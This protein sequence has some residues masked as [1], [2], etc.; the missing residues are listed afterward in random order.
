MGIAATRSNGFIKE[1]TEC[2]LKMRDILIFNVVVDSVNDIVDCFVIKTDQTL[3][4][5][6]SIPFDILSVNT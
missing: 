1:R 4:V 5:V 6:L 2:D 3:F